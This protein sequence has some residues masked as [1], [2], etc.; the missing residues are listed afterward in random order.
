MGYT[1]DLANQVKAREEL[2][3]KG[4]RQVT[5]KKC[6]GLGRKIY[7]GNSV[8]YPCFSCAGR[9]WSWVSPEQQNLEDF[10]RDRNRGIGG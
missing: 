1:E 10:M 9:G 2:E 5:C 6:N 7:A 3:A 8:T 4:Y